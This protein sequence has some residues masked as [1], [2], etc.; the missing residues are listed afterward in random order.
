MK[1]SSYV[2]NRTD[3]EVAQPIHTA[4]C[5]LLADLV[6]VETPPTLGCN[7]EVVNTMPM[8]FVQYR[9]PNK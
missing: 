3:W 9:D 7:P 2:R 8:T 5:E 1:Q 4:Q 6:Q